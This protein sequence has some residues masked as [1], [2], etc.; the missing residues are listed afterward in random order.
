MEVRG[1]GLLISVNPHITLLSVIPIQDSSSAD[2]TNIESFS[3]TVNIFGKKSLYNWT[4]AIQSCVGQR[5]TD[6]IPTTMEC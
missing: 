3:I 2:S 5:S 6:G 4:L 1:T